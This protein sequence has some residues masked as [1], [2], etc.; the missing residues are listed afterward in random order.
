VRRATLSDL[1]NGK[2]TLSTEV[3][4]RLEKAFGVSM[5]LLLRMQA[6]Y[7]APRGAPPQPR[8][9]FAAT[10]PTSPRQLIAGSAS[11]PPPTKSS[12]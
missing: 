5:E 1:A 7:D 9:T 11:G 10:A 6:G 4:L 12:R 2:T 3:A 8:S